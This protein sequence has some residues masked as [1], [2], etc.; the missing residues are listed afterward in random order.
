MPDKSGDSNIQLL[1]CFLC[2]T[3]KNHKAEVEKIVKKL[4]N[5]LRKIDKET[6]KSI[7][8]CNIKTPEG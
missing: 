2:T 8:V 7:H 3:I 1:T 6:F 4:R 5:S